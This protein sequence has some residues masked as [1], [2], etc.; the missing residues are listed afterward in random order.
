MLRQ[1]KTTLWT[2]PVYCFFLQC[3]KTEGIEKLLWT[4]SKR[5]ARND[6]DTSSMKMTRR[7]ADE[8]G[9]RTHS[10]GAVCRV[11]DDPTDSGTF[12]NSEL[13]IRKRKGRT[14]ENGS[15]RRPRSCAKDKKWSP[16]QSRH[17]AS[18]C[19]AA[20]LFPC[21]G[22]CARCSGGRSTGR[23]C[24]CRA[25]RGPCRSAPGSPGAG[26]PGSRARR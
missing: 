12:V 6:A 22:R 4:K 20:E 11:K 8:F 15:G 17:L 5:P 21:R 3:S 10:S 7:P 16:T 1:E 19:R 25:S 18:G 23:G 2:V 26:A 24:S 14:F 9:K 13:Q